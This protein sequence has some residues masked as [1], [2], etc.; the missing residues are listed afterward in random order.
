MKNN[1]KLL[2]LAP[3]SV[4]LISSA[5]A[6]SFISTNNNT[7]ANSSVLLNNKENGSELSDTQ[8][9]FDNNGDNELTSEDFFYYEKYEEESENYVLFSKIVE[10]DK[11]WEG[12]VF[13]YD[14]ETNTYVMQKNVLID[15]ENFISDL[16]LSMFENN[17]INITI[18]TTIDMNGHVIVADDAANNFYNELISS[19][20]M[21]SDEDDLDSLFFIDELNNVTIENGAFIG[22]PFLIN[23]MNSSKLQNVYITDINLSFENKIPLIFSSSL[24]SFGLIINS[25]DDSSKVNG[26]TLL[27][28]IFSFKDLV[29]MG[30]GSSL[31]DTFNFTLLNSSSETL[32][33]N[34]NIFSNVLNID[35]FA[36]IRSLNFINFINDFKNNS[37]IN[38]FDSVLKVENVEDNVASNLNIMISN[39]EIDSNSISLK[40]NEL[41]TSGGTLSETITN[42]G[43]DPNPILP[44]L[45]D[46]VKFEESE[47]V[48]WDENVDFNTLDRHDGD[49][50]IYDVVQLN[51]GNLNTYKDFKTIGESI[52]VSLEKE[53]AGKEIDIN[54]IL[55]DIESGNA[56]KLSY[57]LFGNNLSNNIF[58]EVSSDSFKDDESLKDFDE[59]SFITSTKEAY[60]ELID[61]NVEEH[62]EKVEF[63]TSNEKTWDWI[64]NAYIMDAS[65]IDEIIIKED[66]GESS[67]IN[68]S[69][70][71]NDDDIFAFF[72][73]D[74]TVRIIDEGVLIGGTKMVEYGNIIE[75]VTFKFNGNENETVAYD[76]S[77]ASSSTEDISS[78]EPRFYINPSQFLISKELIY[79][80]TQGLQLIDI[81]SIQIVDVS[82]YDFVG[83]NDPVDNLYN[84]VLDSNLDNRWFIDTDNISPYDPI[85]P[86]N[87]SFSFYIVSS[88]SVLVIILIILIFVLVIRK[89]YANKTAYEDEFDYEIDLT[90]D[91]EDYLEN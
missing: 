53:E 30:S 88:I 14:L 2:M 64:N 17:D 54:D 42:N 52:T 25:I 85:T 40:N 43:V 67:S 20:E 24:K 9:A 66:N 13:N 10:K 70:Y 11:T 50:G 28:N 1:K 47:S 69:S 37:S 16:P 73:D 68:V 39:G 36:S 74:I 31:N 27:N 32:M 8:A 3:L 62:F 5:L 81:N 57:D 83:A 80:E 76:F 35:S 41:S 79:R 18:A 22:V 75:E 60:L 45:Y 65:E 7:K 89:T 6:G 63:K 46:Y 21:I 71:N 29:F 19:L 78:I 59:Q 23:E 26:L 44:T 51:E 33:K 4:A 55:D 91:E 34:V 84:K 61:D 58:L 77:S 72:N 38:I 87:D 49:D 48:L 56:A 12:D 82:Y 15:Y 86:S 90:Q